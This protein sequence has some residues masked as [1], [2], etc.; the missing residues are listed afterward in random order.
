VTERLAARWRMVAVDR[1]YNGHS[2]RDPDAPAAF[3]DAAAARCHAQ[4]RAAVAHG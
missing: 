4:G 3:I 1:P 2:T